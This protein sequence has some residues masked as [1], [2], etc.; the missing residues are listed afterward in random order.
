[1]NSVRS[2]INQ[3]VAHIKTYSRNGLTERLK[4]YPRECLCS[5]NIIRYDEKTNNIWRQY[6]KEKDN[7]C[8]Y[9]PDGSKKRLPDINPKKD[10][11]GII[12]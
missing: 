11:T 8:P 6:L 9:N 2:I 7:W 12:F 5:H 3:T 10:Y 4:C 1:M